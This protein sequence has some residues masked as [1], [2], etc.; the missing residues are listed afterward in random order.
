MTWIVMVAVGLGSYLF[1]LGP[2]LVLQR[3]SLS[4][5]ADQLIRHAGTAA[6]TA[7]IVVSTKQSA[8]GSAAVPTVL[9][10]IVVALELVA[11]S[12]IRFKYM[13][14]PLLSAAFQV[15]LGG[16]LV[17]AAGILIGSS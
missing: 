6:I 16:A 4:D 12:Y 9:A 10:V 15:V 7:L 11:I 8:T 14:T 2:L 13:D 17:F 3:V 5:R 1:R